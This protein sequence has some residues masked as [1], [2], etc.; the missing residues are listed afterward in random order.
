MKSS[1]TVKGHHYDL[2]FGVAE[3]LKSLHHFENR[4]VPFSNW[5]QKFMF[6]QENV[7]QPCIMKDYEVLVIR[8]LFC[9]LL[10]LK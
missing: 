7:L 5:G 8:S 9:S 6:E 10:A 4:A 1:V 2:E 3:I